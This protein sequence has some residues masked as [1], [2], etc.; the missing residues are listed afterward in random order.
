VDDAVARGIKLAGD[1][2]TLMACL[3]D[4][5]LAT[6]AAYASLVESVESL[7][8]PPPL[9]KDAIARTRNRPASTPSP[10]G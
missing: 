4:E 9:E 5:H 3:L 8:L 2:E 1:L 10:Q 6:S 7:P